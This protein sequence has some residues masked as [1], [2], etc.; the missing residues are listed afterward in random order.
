MQPLARLRNGARPLVS[1][2]FVSVARRDGVP[3]QVDAASLRLAVRVPLSAAPLSAVPLSA[4]S[5]VSAPSVVP[6]P[7]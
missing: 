3:A 6:A 1:V 2:A 4:A 7:A 5:L